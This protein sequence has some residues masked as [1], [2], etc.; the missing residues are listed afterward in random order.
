MCEVFLVH[1]VLW[2]FFPFSTLNISSPSFW[3][4]R[5]LLRNPLIAL[6]RFPCMRDFFFS[7]AAFRI[8]P[9]SLV[10][11]SFII[12]CLG[13]DC[14]GLKFWGDLLTPWTLMSRFLPWFGK[15][16]AIISL[17]K[18]SSPFSLFSLSR[19]PIICRFFFY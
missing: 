8:L 1:R 2:S 4:E 9:L 11:D 16:L 17:N 14:F 3:P 10:L 15:F 6:W 13:E 5:F 12:M 18:I 7:L 19:T